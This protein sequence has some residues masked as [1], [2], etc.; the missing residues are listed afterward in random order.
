MVRRRSGVGRL[1]IV[2]NLY[3]L[4]ALRCA[5]PAAVRCE[6]MTA[7]RVGDLALHPV[8]DGVA[9][10]A[11]EMFFGSDWTAHQN[12]LGDDGVL[13]VPVGGFVLETGGRTVLL[14]AGVGE[15]HDEMFD[16]GA[17]LDNLQ[18]LGY[19]PAD[20][21]TVVVSHL[22]SDHM[23]WLE[24]DGAPTF[25]NATVYIGAADWEYFVTGA[26]NGKR[27][28][29]RLRLVEERVELVHTDG[30]CIAPGITT[31]ATPGHTP[32]HMSLVI[33]SGT[34]R[35]L[36]LGDALHCPAQL[37]ESEWQFFFDVDRDLASRTREALLREADEP[38]TSLLPMHFPGM[39]AARLVAGQGARRWIL[40]G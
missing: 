37:T 13:H 17:M 6:T 31:R 30:T 24:S 19:A 18:A 33:S 4:G 22:H 21:D 11:T 32:G 38:G 12:L 35:L 29:E 25:A 34:E 9:R 3:Q 1:H 7:I 28:A 39:Q 10:L 8:L 16:G 15:V 14:D 23:G 5:L 2:N 36:V 26:G 27:R 20:I 40:G